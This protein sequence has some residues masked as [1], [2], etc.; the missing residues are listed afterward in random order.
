MIR[1]RFAVNPNGDCGTGGDSGPGSQGENCTDGGNWNSYCNACH[2]YYGGQHA[3]M[4]CGTAS[5]HEANSLHRIIHT[6]DSG[7]ATHLRITAAGY[8]GDY[9]RPDFTPEILSVEGSA[10]SSELLVTFTMGGWANSDLTGALAPDDFWLFDKNGNNDGRIIEDVVHVAGEATALLT[11]NQPLTTSDIMTD[12]LATRGKAVWAWYEGG[13]VNWATG[14]IEAQAVSAGPWPVTISASPDPT[15]LI[16]KAEGLYSHDKIYVEFSAGAYADL[17]ATG[18]LQPDDFIYTDV[19][20]PAS[21]II[22]VEHT[23][24]S[25]TAVLTMDVNLLTNDLGNDTLSALAGAIYTA[26]SSYMPEAAV[27]ITAVEEPW[28]L[29]VQGVVGHSRLAVWFSEYVYA[30]RHLRDADSCAIVEVDDRRA[31]NPLVSMALCAAEW[32]ARKRW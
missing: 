28:L 11:M 21:T 18:D 5:C 14:T 3:G 25:S 8:E 20:G 26:D 17:D 22:A 31:R 16:T 6:V 32:F 19:S 2:Y 10:G 12:T 30:K 13:Y 27:P 29:V 15:F 24:G 9:H 7:S 1:E 4:S 23:A